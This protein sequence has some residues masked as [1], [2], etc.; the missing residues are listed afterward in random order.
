MSRSRLAA[1]PGQMGAR[2][3]EAFALNAA[4]QFRASPTQPLTSW[5]SELRAWMIQA[6]SP[7][8]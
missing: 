4:R 5:R 3:I 7:H 2:L 1:W 6:G 8:K